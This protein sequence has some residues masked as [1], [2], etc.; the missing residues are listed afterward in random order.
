VTSNQVKVQSNPRQCELGTPP[1]RK[2]TLTLLQGVYLNA[3]E[4]PLGGNHLNPKGCCDF[5]GFGLYHPRQHNPQS[6]NITGKI[7]KVPHYPVSRR[8]AESRF[9]SML[10]QFLRVA[11]LTPSIL[12][13]LR[14]FSPFESTINTVNT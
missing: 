9:S 10:L 12:V 5:V 2:C 11:F 13:V 6:G 7:P 1:R 4:F 3:M 8:V 14:G